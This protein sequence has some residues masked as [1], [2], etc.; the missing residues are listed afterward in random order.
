MLDFLYL[1][2]R[3]GDFMFLK[4]KKIHKIMKWIIFVISAIVFGTI[5]SLYKSFI[6]L[7]IAKYFSIDFI[8]QF[9]IFQI[10]AILYLF[11][12]INY[13]YKEEE[14]KPFNEQVT[15]AIKIFSEKSINL[16][17]AWF[18]IYIISILIL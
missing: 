2:Y 1:L 10:F 17:I 7:E 16:S 3:S 8:L 13:K 5:L 12:V 11:G 18:I 4:S 9:T 14:T 15:R 6:I